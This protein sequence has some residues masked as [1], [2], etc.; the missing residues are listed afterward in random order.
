M[1]TLQHWS[2]LPGGRPPFSP[3]AV[4]GVQGSAV[5]GAVQVLSSLQW[6]GH[7]KQ[8]GPVYAMN[9]GQVTPAVNT[10]SCFSL[11]VRG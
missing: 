7:E 6:G 3:E 10:D 8:E 2:G 11:G 4:V 5:P 1:P 9:G